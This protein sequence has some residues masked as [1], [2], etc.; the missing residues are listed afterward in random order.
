MRLTVIPAR[1]RFAPLFAAMSSTDVQMHASQYIF[2]VHMAMILYWIAAISAIVI[3]RF[4]PSVSSS[5]NYGKLASTPPERRTSLLLDRPILRPA[6]AWPFFYFTGAVTTVISWLGVQS[7]DIRPSSGLFTL[8]FFA[9]QVIRRFSECLFVH[10]HSEK[11]FVT[12]L[13]LGAGTSFYI[14]APLSVFL[15]CD[16]HSIR[17]QSNSDAVQIVLLV[18]SFLLA[19]YAQNHAHRTFASLTPIV[20]KYGIPK[21]P[22]FNTLLCPHY[23]AEVFI[24]ALF[25][26]HA[27]GVETFLMLIFVTCALT[28]SA[29]RTREWYRTTFSRKHLRDQPPYAIFPYIL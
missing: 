10:H 3:K 2:Y 6:I 22:L 14:A 13:Q 18:A 11:N 28:D 4:L 23:F 19:S 8:S 25:A 12:L 27:Q 24:Y 16:F 9:F 26:L 17:I 29:V 20:G 7:G 5:L 15:N 1:F 21:G